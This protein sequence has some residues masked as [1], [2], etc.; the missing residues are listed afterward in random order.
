MKK[1]FS[2]LAVVFTLGLSTVAMD[3]EAAKRLGGGKSVGTQRQA[4][5]DKAP[6]TPPAAAAAAGGAAAT[7]AAASS[8]SWMGPVA[9]IAAGLG[10]AALASHLGFGDELA[11][12]LLIGLLAVTVMMVVG[13]VLR[14]RANAR[15]DAGRPPAPA[16]MQYAYANP[17]AQRPQ[18]KAAADA[19]AYRVAMP[20]PA[21]TG[22]AIGSG[23][24]G[25]SLAQA[26]IAADFDCA[27]F[28]HHAKANFIRLQAANDTGNLDDI[29]QFTTPE[30][31]AELA[32][33]LSLR[34][35][36]PQQTEV[37]QLQAQ[38]LEALE[39]ADQF[40]V[41]VRFSGQLRTPDGSADDEAFDEVWHL[42]KARSGHGG[43]LLCGI[44]QSQSVGW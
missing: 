33:D 22:S 23:L 27:S 34:D 24:H 32:H 25:G 3:A 19:P 20:A 40:R 17:G 14:K 38:V 1:L 10:L 43:W 9:G 13:Y 29:R 37:L 39:D 6:A 15:S 8:R 5:V 30:L 16:G 36:T 11:S 28:E 26:R 42:T 4:T 44:A 12:M 21:S 35:A 31:F 41:S 7:G 18:D 2:M